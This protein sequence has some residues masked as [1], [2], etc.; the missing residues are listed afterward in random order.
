MFSNRLLALLICVGLAAL[1][2]CSGEPAPEV[3]DSP[4]YPVSA[5]VDQ[6][7]DYHGTAVADPYRWLEDPDSEQTT[8]W[9]TAQNVL[10]RSVLDG[11]P[12]REEIRERLSEMMDY[13]RYSTPVERGGRIFFRKNDGLQ[14]QSVLYVQDGPDA[15]PRVLLD[16]NTLSE[17]G[18]IAMGGTSI[19][20]DGEL[21]AWSRIDGGSDWR[22][23]LIR[24]VE[25]GED[26]PDLVRWSKFSG[27]A[28]T[29]DG[30]GFFYGRYDAPAEGEELQDANFNQKLFYHRVGTDQSADELVY[31]NDEHKEWSFHAQVS[32]DGAWLVMP[33]Q[34]SS[35]GNN[36]IYVRPLA[37]GDFIELLPDFDAIYEFLGNDGDALYFMTT[38]DAPRG[39]IVAIDIDRPAPESWR[40]IV[41]ENDDTI[42]K[43]GMVAD[44]FIVVYMQDAHSVVRT[45]GVDG[46]DLGTIEMPGL[47]S[48]Y[49]FTGR[50]ADTVSYYGFESFLSPDVIRRHDFA[51]GETTVFHAPEIDFP[52]HEFVTEQV[53]YESKDGTRVPMFL[54]HR[55]DLVRDGT[56]PCYLYG[57]GGFNVSMTPWFS[58]VRLAW[59]DRGGMFAMPNIRGGGEYGEQWHQAGTIHNKQNVFDDF[60]AAA[61]WLIAEAYTSTGKLAIGGGSNGG[62]LVG[63]CLNQRP[64]LFG[65]ALPVVGVMDMLRYHMFTI[66][67]AWAS[68]YGTSD[69]PEQF[70]TL[71]RYSPYHNIQDGTAYPA[72]LVTTAD[73]DDRV[74]PGHSFKYAARLQAAQ[75]GPAPTLIR[76]ETRAGHS[77]GKPTD[78][79]IEEAA[80][81][82]A[83]LVRALGME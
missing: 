2:G 64:D 74:V 44:R 28:W 8:A 76:I 43:S 66:G 37:G 9:V 12:A 20:D 15:E 38:K 82:W 62:T 67:W 53:F 50:R 42:E 52:F 5:T 10:T 24:D 31:K 16:P 23:W 3:W 55:K 49:G 68:D 34:A 7:D 35:S 32:E 36:S 27:A 1:I 22:T 26:L 17:D 56:N 75:A 47:G 80:D 40:T 77:S 25:T 72:V 11:I 29:P 81:E 41:P 45:Y 63:A 19:S 57:Y 54:V 71:Y 13:T 73:H 79:I 6:T 48:A 33:V 46:S 51:T 60:I 58:S 69:D 65:A 59:F 21:I 70:E 39:R 14:P 83:F 30:K 61:E 4:A 18:T 78:K